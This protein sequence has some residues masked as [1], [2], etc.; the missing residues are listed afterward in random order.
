MEVT[1]IQKLN[2]YLC[3]TV[4]LE[5]SEVAILGRCL[6]LRGDHLEVQLYYLSQC[7][8]KPTIRLV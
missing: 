3:K 2:I 5:I 7:T 8:T 6:L 1:V 4:L